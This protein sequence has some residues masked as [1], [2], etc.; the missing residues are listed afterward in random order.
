MNCLV[1]LV[2]NYL[3]K[4]C[5]FFYWI[6]IY[7][8]S[9]KLIQLE[10]FKYSISIESNSRLHIL[11]QTLMYSSKTSWKCPHKIKRKIQL[12]SY[13]V[14]KWK[15]KSLFELNCLIP[16]LLGSEVLYLLTCNLFGTFYVLSTN[17]NSDRKKIENI[18]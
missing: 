17:S 4:F 11:F 14:E 9:G 3:E 8:N 18:L 15:E 2:Q 6:M 7:H 10:K 12:L 5:F 16:H 13:A 1:K